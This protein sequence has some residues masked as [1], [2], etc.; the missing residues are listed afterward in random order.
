MIHVINFTLC[1]GLDLLVCFGASQGITG[2][3]EV[4]LEKRQFGHGA[5]AAMVD[6]GL[7]NDG[8]GGRV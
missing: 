6:V 7:G 3:V 4:W 2:L 5:S 1:L 8:S